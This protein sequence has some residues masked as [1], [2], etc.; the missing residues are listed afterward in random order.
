MPAL[1]ASP[2]ALVSA[3]SCLNCLSEKELKAVLVYCMRT[4]AG[5][6]LPQVVSG[7]A[8]YACMS[9][10]QM[11]VALTAMVANQLT[12]TLTGRN[13]GSLVPCK[14]CAS[15]KQIDSMLLFLFANFFQSTAI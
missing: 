5:L 12:P 11:L 2:S 10:K 6:T 13:L 1:T 15:D 4:S 3:K 8:C 14:T 7:S 9:K